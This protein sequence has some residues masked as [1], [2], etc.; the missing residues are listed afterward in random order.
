MQSKATA[1][2]RIFVM[3]LREKTIIVAARSQSA[4]G[5][6]SG[7]LLISAVFKFSMVIL[8]LVLCLSD[9]GTLSESVNEFQAFPVFSYIRTF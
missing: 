6:W 7:V 1:W 3:A 5:R 2:Y 4:F 9:A 8:K